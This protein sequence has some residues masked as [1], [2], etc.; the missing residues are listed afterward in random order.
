MNILIVEDSKVYANLIKASMEK[1]LL[2]AKCDIAYSFEEL[3]NLDKKYDL[4]IID[5]ILPDTSGDE[6]IKFLLEQ[7][8]KIIVMTQYEDKIYKSS[9]INEI[10]DFIIKEDISIINYLIRLVRRIYKNQF[11]NV[12]VVD[13]S[14]AIRIYQKKILKLLNL[15]VFEAENGAESLEV[16]KKENINFV[17]TDIE[18]PKLNGV[19]MVKEIRKIKKIDELPILVLSSTT[20]LFITFQILKLGAND[21]IK[22]PF[23]KNEYII[24]INNILD[25]YDYLIN[26]KE[27]RTIDGLTK[28]YNRF[29]LENSF[30][31]I[32]KFYKE[33]VVAM[34]DIDFFKKIND[35]YG[36]QVG[37]KIL[38]YFAK[39]IKN[40]LRKDD[41]IIRYG[42]EEFLVFMPNTTKEEAYIVLHKI[43]NSLK[44]VD[45]IKFTFSAG[46]A[47]EGETMAE[48]I[49]KADERLYKAKEEGRNR[50]VYKG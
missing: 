3:K 43:K 40:N 12:L 6:H 50:I 39:H 32:F 16:I 28:V 4:Y 11:K 33:K 44:D 30:E 27:E 46:I 10:I 45:E 48:M 42:G 2:F 24:R 36:H 21:F 35:T 5:Y 18:M 23:D 19:E 38:A 22:K 20:N 17:I 47:N 41:L 34:L 1:Y 8:A 25:I 49:K 29:F 26:Y 9:F 15:N 31:T 13:D 7:H 14:K 37:D